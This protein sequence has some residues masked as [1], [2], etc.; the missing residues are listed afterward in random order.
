M[1]VQIGQASGAIYAS[2]AGLAPPSHP[3][4]E[5]RHGDWLAA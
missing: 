2:V 3:A 5:L 4:I 1:V